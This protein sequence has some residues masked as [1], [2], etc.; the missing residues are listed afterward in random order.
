V[1]FQI[2]ESRKNNTKTAVGVSV[3]GSRQPQGNRQ[4]GFVATLKDNFGFI[5][6]AE[7]DREIF[8]H[9]RCIFLCNNSLSFI[10]SS[11]IRKKNPEMTP[12]RTEKENSVYPSVNRFQ[13]YINHENT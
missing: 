9:F 12:H 6:T 3:A 2:C 5:E 11:S 4:H 7:H 13:I 1:E 8:F 10:H